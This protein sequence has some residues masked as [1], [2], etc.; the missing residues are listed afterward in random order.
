M[1]ARGVCILLLATLLY[2]PSSQA[3]GVEPGSPL[4]VQPAPKRPP[5]PAA[6]ASSRGLSLS[7]F[8]E[9]PGKEE[10]RIQLWLRF[11]RSATEIE[12]GVG[13]FLET[14]IQLS[15]QAS[16]DVIYVHERVRLEAEAL[17]SQQE[18]EDLRDARTELLEELDREDPERA[19][20]GGEKAQPWSPDGT[21]DRE[22]LAG[23]AF[24]P[25][26]RAGSLSRDM[27][28]VLGRLGTVE[29]RLDD[30]EH[31]LLPIAEEALGSSLLALASGEASMLEVIHGLH[32]LKHQ[33]RT[34]L[35]LRVHR[36]LLLMELARQAGCRVDQ[37][38]WVFSPVA[39]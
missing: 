17:A 9:S 31:Q 19:I 2:V 20:L 29:R 10:A 18:I 32:F 22:A 35:E 3:G 13:D 24:K 38:P 21:L 28:R 25:K 6:P 30:V 26:G 8:L 1:V 39:G 5:A 12:Q 36:E 4:A 33:Q 34:R 11:N 23:P 14:L 37:L 27:E 15:A 7:R 16:Q